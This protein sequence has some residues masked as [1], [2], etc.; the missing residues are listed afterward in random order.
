MRSMTGEAVVCGGQV[1]S[2]A[3]QKELWRARN[4]ALC[5]MKASPMWPRLRTAKNR[6]IKVVHEVGR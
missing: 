3:V 2:S 4:A 6:A 5:R 1:T